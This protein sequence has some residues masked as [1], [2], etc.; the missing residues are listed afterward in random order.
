MIKKRESSPAAVDGRTRRREGGRGADWG[1]SPSHL[2]IEKRER[3]RERAPNYRRAVH[4][5]KR[6]PGGDHDKQRD[7]RI[8][9]KT[10]WRRNSTAHNTSTYVELVLDTENRA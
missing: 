2:P 4:P 10:F 3:E 7:S 5:K 8:R 9:E 6:A 1:P